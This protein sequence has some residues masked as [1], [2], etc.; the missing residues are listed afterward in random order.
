MPGQ[1][2]VKKKSTGQESDTEAMFSRP[3]VMRCLCGCECVC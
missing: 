1:K 3:E 2:C